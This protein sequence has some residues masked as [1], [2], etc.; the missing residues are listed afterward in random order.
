MGRR[1]DHSREQLQEMIIAESLSLVRQRG[2]DKV[3]AR[4]IAKAI[5]YTPGMLYSVFI[6]LQDIFLHV[7]QIGLN[8]L[9]EL[10]A[11]AQ[12]R[13]KSPE[14]ALLSMGQTYLQFAREHTHQFDL[15]FSRA[16]Q[17]PETPPPG[18]GDQIRMLF[19][20]LGAQLRQLR[21]SAS[22]EDIRQ[23]ALALWAGVHGTAALR[24]SSQFHLEASGTDG[25]IMELLTSSFIQHWKGNS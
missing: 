1:S 8:T 24:L 10:C 9:Y 12:R 20:L 25:K 23:G 2:A 17:H 7:N 13:S 18:L 14:E 4:Q 19:E 15:M 3:T 11:A 5:G 6:N 16:I 21:P 22:D